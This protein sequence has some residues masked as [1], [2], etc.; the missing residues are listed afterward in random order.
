MN[1]TVTT[2]AENI[3]IGAEHAW[4]SGIAFLPKFLMF[5]LI[6][7]IGYFAAKVIGKAVDTI[8]ERV[9]FDGLVER[10]GVKRALSRSQWDASDILSKIVFYTIFLFVLQLAFG[11]FGANAISE[12]LTRVVSYL[13]NVFVAIL[14]VI[15]AAA[16]ANAV[17]NII[18]ASLGG[19]NYGRFLATGAAVAIW[20]V[21]AFAA[22]DQLEIAENITN[23]LFYAI[24]AI[25]VGSAVIA[26][27]GGGIV[28]MRARWE[29]WLNRLEAEAPNVQARLREGSRGARSGG[30]Q[31]WE[32]D[33]DEAER[34]RAGV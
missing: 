18:S 22:L 19:L 30:S 24:L 5:L 13:P 25:V 26:I 27:G 2:T 11:V 32:H 4:A 17:S 7:I 3:R 16:V 20:I 8:L 14:I 12:L 6:L 23:G 1:E 15:I 9:G 34:G 29:R 33:L 21:G 31:R 28:P 10:G